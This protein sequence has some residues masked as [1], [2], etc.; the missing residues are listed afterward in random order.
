MTA[1]ARRWLAA[2][3]PAALAA[4]C[5]CML[6]LGTASAAS[7]EPGMSTADLK[8]PMQD[9]PETG[10][11]GLLSLTSSVLPLQVPWLAPGD[12]FSWQIGL[13]LRDQPAAD[14]GLQFIPDGGLIDQGTGYRF[15]AHSCPTQWLG[16]SGVNSQLSCPSG[17]STLVEKDILQ[18]DPAATMPLD[19]LSANGSSHIL[20]TLSLPEGAAS[21]GSFTFALGFTAMGD[22]TTP[23]DELPLTGF[24]A[25]LLPVAG[26]LITGG[27]IARLVPRKGVKT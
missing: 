11:P 24:M 21:S 5:F 4:V 2:P 17:A 7:A 6:T 26:A 18:M 9:V 22:E 3:G 19:D 20:F 14:A 25:G 12:S 15:T 1:R 16:R 10:T 23:A 8:E 13:H 27:L